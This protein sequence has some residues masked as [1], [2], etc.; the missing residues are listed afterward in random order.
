MFKQSCLRCI[1]GIRRENFFTNSEDERKILDPKTQLIEQV[2]NKSKS[3]WIGNVLRMPTDR[4]LRC[5]LFCEASISWKISRSGHSMTCQP[6]IE[7]STIGLASVGS[8]RLP[9]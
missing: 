6:N 3:R 5:T 2:L 4:L 7:T 1:N 9:G 8:V